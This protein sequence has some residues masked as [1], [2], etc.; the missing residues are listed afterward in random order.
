ML[1]SMSW[2]HSKR[3]SLERCRHLSKAAAM[4]SQRHI[5]IYLCDTFEDSDSERRIVVQ[6]V[7]EERRRV[8]LQF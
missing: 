8:D 2:P 7:V 3:W 5:R 4:T 6:V 1:N